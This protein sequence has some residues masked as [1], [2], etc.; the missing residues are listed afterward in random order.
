M[1]V[2][3]NEDL[4]AKAL[5]CH[6]QGKL[7]DA[8]LQYRHI[9]QLEDNAQA[10]ANLGVALRSQGHIEAAIVAYQQALLLKPDH[11][12]ALS[13]LGGALRALG[14]LE[15]AAH[16]LHQALQLQPALA[17]AHHNLGLVYM[18]GQAPAKAIDAFERA[19]ALDPMLVDAEFERATCLM[20]TGDLLKGFAAYECRFRYEKKLKKPFSQPQ[21]DGSALNGKT[22]LI[23]VEQGF[24]DTLQFVRYIPLIE[25]SGGR[26][27][28]EAHQPLKGLMQTVQGVDQ[29]LVQGERIPAFDVYISLLSLP[30]VFKTIMATI[31]QTIPY[32]GAGI[33]Q[34]ALPTAAKP[35]KL[36]VGLVWSNGFTNI[37][38]RQR[39]LA[40]TQ[41]LPLLSLPDI[42]FYSLQKGNGAEELAAG[43]FE[44]FILDLEPVIKDFTDTA[45]LIQ[46]LDLLIT[47][48]TASAHLGGALGIPTW[49]LLPY[50]SDWR[51][52]LNRSDSPWYPSLRLFRQTKPFDWDSQIMDV[53]TALNT[54]EKSSIVKNS[55]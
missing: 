35:A 50:G 5:E 6:Q 8:I 42:T 34:E 43:G 10:F 12:V 30:H 16:N 26:I 18:D 11:A 39:K 54:Y 48:D 28:L 21:W 49:V 53:Q 40:L 27:L 3:P 36:K 29:V 47:V 13:N 23:C 33:P 46:Q 2:S 14:R 38:T 17:A 37:G 52:F 15:V 7:D 1:P 51:W 45:S 19:L 22:L 41:F 25:K 44:A 31:P 24:G 32:V 9:I 20:Q 55:G 4:F